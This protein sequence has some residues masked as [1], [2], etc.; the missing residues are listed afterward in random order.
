MLVDSS[1]IK[2]QCVLEQVIVLV[3][4]ISNRY[5]KKLS[6]LKMTRL[7]LLPPTKYKGWSYRFI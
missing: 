4:K 6:V 7:K 5:K 3:L 1:I 2:N